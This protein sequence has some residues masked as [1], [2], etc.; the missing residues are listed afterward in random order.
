M[1]TKQPLDDPSWMVSLVG[2]SASVAAG[3]APF[4]CRPYLRSFAHPAHWRPVSLSGS[5]FPHDDGSGGNVAR[6]DDD[7]DEDDGDGD[8]TD[9]VPMGRDCLQLS[10]K[11]PH[12]YRS[13]RTLPP[14][15]NEADANDYHGSGE[16]CPEISRADGAHSNRWWSDHLQLLY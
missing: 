1:R 2:S 14:N 8:G 9:I 4:D 6:V 5:A 15:G 7:A 16:N 13:W 3:E 12:H 11:W 10:C